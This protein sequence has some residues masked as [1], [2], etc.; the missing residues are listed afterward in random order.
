MF[1][2]VSCAMTAPPSLSDRP[3]NSGRKSPWPDH[4]VIASTAAASTASPAPIIILLRAGRAARRA[5]KPGTPLVVAG[6]TLAV[7][8]RAVSMGGRT[9]RER[10]TAHPQRCPDGA[11]YSG[12]TPQESRGQ[13]EEA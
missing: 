3:V 2:V 7:G 11:N 10:F 13:G 6:R 8:L 5:P 9:T 4:S 1:S 12:L